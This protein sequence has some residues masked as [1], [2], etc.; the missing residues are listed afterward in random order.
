MSKGPV[1]S[2]VGV[3][4]TFAYR[5][6]RSVL[7]LIRTLGAQTRPPEAMALVNFGDPCPELERV[8]APF[9]YI[10]RHLPQKLPWSLAIAEN[11]GA[12]LL[13]P[14]ETVLFLDADVLLAPDFIERG[15]RHL[16]PGVMVNCRLMDLP[17][18]AVTAKTDV[19]REFERLK[20]ISVLRKEITAV[21]ACQ[22]MRMRALHAMR[23]HDETFKMWCF[24]DMDFQRRARWLG[25]QP[26]HLDDETSMLHQWHRPKD[27][28]M[29]D[30]KAPQVKAARYWYRKNLSLLRLRALMWDIGKY[31][32][33]E[34]NPK[35][36]GKIPE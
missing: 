5:E 31:D 35:G 3:V 33:E 27:S 8:T 36:W 24:E 23:G 16:T 9:D 34:I 18:G 7:N 12:L 19:V 6:P 29:K 26:V 30:I 1:A 11:Q 25:L 22:W 21:G 14:V 17:K 28:V 4:V 15:L 20:S 2:S 10:Y 32:P 13:P